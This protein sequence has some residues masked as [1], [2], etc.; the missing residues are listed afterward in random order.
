MIIIGIDISLTGTGVVVLKNDQVD[1]ELLIK[2]KPPEEKNNVTEIER[3]V[4][5]VNKIEDIIEKYKPDLVSIENMAFGVRNATSLTQLSYINYAIRA[6]LWASNIKFI[7]VAPKSLKKF[8]T[9]NGNADKEEMMLE[10]FQKYKIAFTEDN[11]CDAF[12]LAVVGRT[13]LNNS[14]T[15]ENEKEVI[16]KLKTQYV[17]R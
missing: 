12:C 9:G 3:L 2:S 8:I 10:V 13:I 14:A 15:K 17:T 4:L 1:S 6:Y 7:L 16:E 11:C 5:I